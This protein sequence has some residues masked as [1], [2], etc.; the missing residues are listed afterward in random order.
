YM[1]PPCLRTTLF[2][3]TTLFRSDWNDFT[4]DKA[5]LRSA[6][7]QTK[8]GNETRAYDA[9]ELALNSLRLIQGRKAIVIFTDGVDWHSETSSF[10]DRKSTRLNS[11]HLVISYAV[12]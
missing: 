7:S 10:K 4:S 5:A 2:P 12:F 1:K 6:I 11:S 3:Y 8:T 9:V